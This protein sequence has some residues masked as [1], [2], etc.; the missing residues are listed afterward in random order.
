[1][2]KTNE[3][4]QSA[5]TTF[6]TSSYNYIPASNWISIGY[7]QNDAQAMEELQNEMKI[8]CDDSEEPEIILEGRNDDTLFCIMVCVATS[9]EKLG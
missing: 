3:S 9:L 1:M 8:Y 4:K 7:S 5:R 2:Y 6:E